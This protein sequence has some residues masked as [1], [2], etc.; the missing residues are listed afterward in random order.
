MEDPRH[1]ALYNTTAEACWTRIGWYQKHFGAT[2][3]E[4]PYLQPALVD[5]ADA[6]PLRLMWTGGNLTEG[7]VLG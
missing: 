4:C 3:L 7:Q 2:L 1:A 6:L 5:G